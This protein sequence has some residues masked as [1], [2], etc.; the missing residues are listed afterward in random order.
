MPSQVVPTPNPTLS[1]QHQRVATL[2]QKF[3][4]RLRD[5][6]ARRR[7]TQEEFAEMLEVSVGLSKPDRAWQ[8][9]TL[10]RDG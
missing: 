10:V 8:E 3:G 4:R 9:C 1:T 2:R 6:R 7:M 5:I